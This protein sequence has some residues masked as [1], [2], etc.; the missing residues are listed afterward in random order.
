M[1]DSTARIKR[2]SL[3]GLIFAVGFTIAAF[4]LSLWTKV[5]TADILFY[6]SLNTAFFAALL[7][8]E[9]RLLYK[10]DLESHEQD[11]VRKSVGASKEL[12]DESDE[13]M[14]LAS[15][16][17]KAWRSFLLPAISLVYG[18]GAI[19]YFVFKWQEWSAP[20]AMQME[21]Q[22]AAAACAGALG[23]CYFLIGA[24]YGG[25]SRQPDGLKLRPFSSWAYFSSIVCAVLVVVLFLG[26]KQYPQIDH[27]SHRILI[28]LLII[29]AFELSINFLIDWYRP[30]F[31][32]DEKSILESR[33][34]AVFTDSGSIAS[35]IAHALDYQF[36]LKISESGFYRFL[37]KTLAP[38][39]IVQ[40]LTLYLLSCFTLIET[41]QRG[42]RETLGKVDSKTELVPGL[43]VKLPWPLSKI[44]V[45]EADKI[46]ILEV[47][48]QPKR[49]NGPEAPPEDEQATV[50]VTQDVS[51]WSKSG[52]HEEGMEDINFLISTT[53]NKDDSSASQ[54]ALGQVNMITV[55]V[56]IQYRIKKH[57]AGETSSL[58]KYL[59]EHAN[60]KTTLKTLVSEVV[61]EFLSS[62]DYY[63]FLGKDRQQASID[64][65]KLAQTE[66]DKLGLGVEIVALDLETSHPPESVSKSYDDVIAAT[67]E[68]DVT[69]F[70]ADVTRNRILSNAR[71]NEKD[72]IMD[73]ES[74]TGLI[75]YTDE[76]GKKAKVPMK[77]AMAKE[78]ATR[79]KSQLLSYNS[80]PYLFSLINYLSVIEK[81]L[82]DTRKIIIDSTKAD[83]NFRFDL[84]PKLAPDLEN[85]EIPE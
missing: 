63:D 27:Y 31:H 46:Q 43:Y 58:Y 70:D 34:L 18:I 47:G 77:L 54:Q 17:L 12:F 32:K 36:G 45:Y 40:L 19:I 60:A 22:M 75:D 55:V 2:Y 76:S 57:V 71:I 80:Q 4:A 15:R 50:T 52:H 82:K 10:A 65:L 79:L 84:K 13:A 26:E 21:N 7:F 49:D 72:L 33:F 69:V 44:H 42:L 74:V 3:I 51:L 56:P 35:N 29:M 62:A 48:Q 39:L 20:H 78:K 9:H 25:A 68:K 83:Y 81:G 66:A 38:L 41:G 73:A 53:P 11:E 64:L 16:S 24:F 5:Y 61:M 67:Y 30:R 85:L 28:T 14:M 59:F 37:G 6:V 8:N 23:V 1:T